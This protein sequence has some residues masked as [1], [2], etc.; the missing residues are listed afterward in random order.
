MTEWGLFN[1]ESADWTEGEAVETG[2]WSREEAEQ[3]VKDRYTP[4]D[5]LTVH[6]VEE[7]EEDEDDNDDHEHVYGPF[8]LSRFAGTPH[9]KCQVAGCKAW[10]LDGDDE[11]DE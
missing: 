2:F 6:A 1:D 3:A 8:E 5:E 9:R 7:A 4:E 11:D 10:T